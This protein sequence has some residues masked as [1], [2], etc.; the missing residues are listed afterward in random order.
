[1]PAAYQS[2]SGNWTSTPPASTP[3]PAKSS[4]PA[5]SAPAPSHSSGSSTPS[6]LQ[7]TTGGMPIGDNSTSLHSGPTTVQVTPTGAIQ[8]TSTSTS[9]RSVTSTQ[10]GPDTRAG[11]VQNVGVDAASQAAMNAARQRDADA[12]INAQ[13]GG[14]FGVGATPGVGN[15]FDI[16][17]SNDPVTRMLESQGISMKGAGIYATRPDIIASKGELR[18]QYNEKVDAL[19][20]S[21]AIDNATREQLKK[22]YDPVLL[23]SLQRAQA[24]DA[25]T[26]K[27]NIGSVGGRSADIFKAT[28]APEA[29]TSV[30][31][32][33]TTFIGTFGGKPTE[34]SPSTAKASDTVISLLSGRVTEP[35]PGRIG[36]STAPVIKGQDNILLFRNPIPA[37]TSMTGRIGN[38]TPP[39]GAPSSPSLADV[40]RMQMKLGMVPS[41]QAAGEVLPTPAEQKISMMSGMGIAGRTAIAESASPVLLGFALGGSLG[42][43]AATG[44]ARIGN[45]I[46]NML[47]TYNKGAM[48]AGIKAMNAITTSTSPAGANTSPFALGANLGIMAIKGDIAAK[49]DV[50]GI[51]KA[52]PNIKQTAS[53]AAREINARATYIPTYKQ[54]AEQ[55]KG[56]FTW[57]TNKQLSPADNPKLQGGFLGAG[58]AASAA[59]GKAASAFKQTP[60]GTYI[61]N[62]KQVS[63]ADNPNL[64]G[65]IGESIFG[66][67]EIDKEITN[68]L[69]QTKELKEKNNLP[70]KS[71]AEVATYMANIT[72]AAADLNVQGKALEQEK[73]D[74][75]PTYQTELVGLNKDADALK[76]RLSTLNTDLISLD[77]KIAN[78]TATSEEIAAYGIK[79][80]AYE[81]DRLAYNNRKTQYD[82]VTKS[83]WDALTARDKEYNAAVDTLKTKADQAVWYTREADAKYVQD[84]TAQKKDAAVSD[85][86]KGNYAHAL[87]DVFDIM[88]AKQSYQQKYFSKGDL[89]Y[90]SDIYFNPKTSQFENVGGGG[91]AGAEKMTPMLGSKDTGQFMFGIPGF[92]KMGTGLWSKYEDFVN[93]GAEKF[94]SATGAPSAA[95]TSMAILGKTPSAGGMAAAA[96][97]ALW[98]LVATATQRDMKA[99]SSKLREQYG[100]SGGA[101]GEALGRWVP[102]VL[103]TT[104]ALVDWTRPE[105]I[106]E[107]KALSSIIGVVGKAMGDKTL[108]AA[109]TIAEKEGPE[110]GRQFLI[111]ASEKLP[112]IQGAMTS[113]FLAI[114]AVQT[115]YGWGETILEKPMQQ[116]KEGG[117]GLTGLSKVTSPFGQATFPG[118]NFGEYLKEKTASPMSFFLPTQQEK[119]VIQYARDIALPLPGSQRETI[120]S[121]LGTTA[122]IGALGA[123]QVADR[124]LLIDAVKAPTAKT[125]ETGEVVTLAKEGVWKGLSG[126]GPEQRIFSWSPE[127]G[128]QMGGGTPTIDVSTLKARGVDF[129][130]GLGI[131]VPESKATFDTTVKLARDLGIP[132]NSVS[133]MQKEWQFVQDTKNIVPLN[134][135]EQFIRST[136]TS[137][138]AESEAIFKIAKQTSVLPG[139]GGSTSVGLFRPNVAQA[140]TENDIALIN[141]AFAG[142]PAEM[143][144]FTDAVKTSWGRDLG[145][146]DIM[147]LGRGQTSAEQ[148]AVRTEVAVRGLQSQAGKKAGDVFTVGTDV[149]KKISGQPAETQAQFHFEGQM[150]TD[151][152]NLRS[153]IKTGKIMSIDVNQPGYIK[154]GMMASHPTATLADAVEGTNT[155]REMNGKMDV[156]PSPGREK[157][158]SMKFG[159]MFER[160]MSAPTE[161]EK[162]KLLGDIRDIIASNPKTL[163]GLSAGDIGT[164]I[165]AERVNTGKSSQFSSFANK[166]GFGGVSPAATGGAVS[167]ATKKPE[168]ESPASAISANLRDLS[169]IS[170]PNI[171]IS[172]MTS[173]SLGIST[174]SKPST[175]S[176]PSS[177]ASSIGS[178]MYTS[179]PE[180]SIPSSISSMISMPSSVP[181]SE[182]SSQPPS[183]Q[184]PS[185]QPSS[186][187]S[188]AGSV[189]M[190]PAIFAGLGGGGG[191]GG[192]PGAGPSYG[193][194]GGGRGT[195]VK[196]RLIPLYTIKGPR[197]KESAEERAAGAIM[198]TRARAE[199]GGLGGA[200][201]MG[202]MSGMFGGVPS[203]SSMSGSMSDKMMGMM[204]KTTQSSMMSQMSLGSMEGMMGGVGRTQGL[205]GSSRMR[206]PSVSRGR[207]QSF[208][209]SPSMP[210]MQGMTVPGGVR[211]TS[212]PNVARGTSMPSGLQ[213][214]SIPSRGKKS[215]SFSMPQGMSMSQRMSS[216][217]EGMTGLTRRVPSGMQGMNG[218]TS[219]MTSKTSPGVQRMPSGM[220]GMSSGMRGMPVSTGIKHVPEMTSRKMPSGMNGMSGMV[221][222]MSGKSMSQSMPGGMNGMSGMVGKMTGR[223]MSQG[224]SGGMMSKMSVPR[225]TTKYE[226]RKL[227]T[228]R[229]LIRNPNNK[230]VNMAKMSK[231]EKWNLPKTKK[232][233]FVMG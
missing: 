107:M 113:A 29:A 126:K 160:A 212:I 154:E 193:A 232:R 225:T 188:P 22:V 103:D 222:K 219:R 23:S 221:G 206:V 63:P 73:A 205:V 125:A 88:D 38:A 142:N 9:G 104:S 12:L 32:K 226:M 128:F 110:A 198:G 101:K 189:P 202:G 175:S 84:V 87:Q 118:F 156:G 136:R 7:G 127:Q 121:A 112:Q 34:I 145:D 111:K 78:G 148:A 140:I 217:M 233:K 220:R 209:E 143:K 55:L 180:S 95:T 167:S 134:I 208:V 231:S 18:K 123:K 172:K 33:I 2:A 214:I 130:E 109:K 31:D 79:R 69:A 144:L 141:K 100:S 173:Q 161:G 56:D 218:M 213:G 27:T 11:T 163:Q 77:K 40:Y 139:V 48:Q 199:M 42:T 30:A 159:M 228:E 185:S 58:T 8:T 177:I 158:E 157:A 57:L 50:E 124:A 47:G 66:T 83:D 102:G 80:D 183:S 171:D 92:A 147:L 59:L 120:A 3:A 98:N 146:A 170:T 43:A 211:G 165:A 81:Q 39:S 64:R 230:R 35:S 187:S 114:P 115:A 216:N 227:S 138:P 52:I 207:R 94:S 5:P 75:L 155:L 190:I 224:M 215:Q 179:Y 1:M 99:E 82:T 37:P 89:G 129:K 176:L 184:P 41:A 166:L 15:V 20:S 16:S 149:F 162:I 67:K 36:T 133:K 53:D 25:T 137:S 60:L 131:H 229:P 204:G 168:T 45:K 197:F 13:R 196:K 24:R 76:E 26:I 191:G 117:G 46:E 119:N 51:S 17:R 90:K 201:G 135:Q 106:M 192:L 44:A 97:S 6:Y 10:Y 203:A 223:S 54:A 96:G 178:S 105:A 122:V 86:Y 194:G 19:R 70:E 68:V 182:P 164:G 49:K 28:P 150:P 108:A 74:K 72:K 116:W 153:G 62:V 85:F 195:G 71:P 14:V 181:S 151:V 132:E 210:N 65:G 169:G 91:L 93:A 200:F 21:G 174:P 186:G 61:S 152:V 4:S